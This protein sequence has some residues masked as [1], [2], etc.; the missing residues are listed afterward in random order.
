MSVSVMRLRL[1]VLGVPILFL[2][3][4]VI[5]AH[6]RS[7][8]PSQQKAINM[9]VS[10]HI[11]GDF[12]EQSGH[13]M[14]S[15]VSSVYAAHGPT[16]HYTAIGQ[17]VQMWKAMTRDR[18]EDHSFPDGTP[19]LHDPMTGT[20]I[21]QFGAAYFMSGPMGTDGIASHGN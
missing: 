18:T 19:M 5:G 12:A 2:M 14:K 1:G 3:A 11:S 13:Y 17:G 21:G 4:P 15:S 16:L 8:P 20:A 9:F 6:I 10:S 7:V